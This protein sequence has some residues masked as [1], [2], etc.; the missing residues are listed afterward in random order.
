MQPSDYRRVAP[1]PSVASCDLRFRQHFQQ[2]R[3][4]RETTSSEAQTE[5][6][7]PV[8]KLVDCLEGFQACESRAVKEPN[9][10]F[11]STPAVISSTSWVKKINYG[12]NELNME[13][14]FQPDKAD[15]DDLM[16]PMTLCDSAVCDVELS[17]AE[18]EQC[19]LSDV[20]SPDTL[21]ACDESQS[22]DRDYKRG[23][24]EMPCF[25]SER[26]GTN[27]VGKGSS[28]AQDQDS[29][30]HVS[31]R[32]GTSD[33]FEGRTSIQKEKFKNL[34]TDSVEVTEP[35]LQMTADCNL[36][37]QI[38]HL[39]CNKNTTDYLLQK[40]V[41]PL[42]YV[43]TASALLPSKQY[44]FGSPYTH[45]YYPQVV[46]ERQ[47]VLSPSLDELS[48]R[49][50]MFS[51]DAEEDL[52][53]GQAYVDGG[54]LAETGAVSTRSE[55]DPTN[56]ACSVWAKTCACC[57][58]S[59]PDEDLSPIELMDQDCDCELEDDTEAP[60][61]GEAPKTVRKYLPRHGLS[62]CAQVSKHKDGKLLE[63]A[64]PS[65]QDQDHS[66]GGCGEQ[67]HF[68]AKGE[69]GRTKGPKGTQFRSHSGK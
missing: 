39:P 27:H 57:G 49:D 67:H 32:I 54:T 30:A 33:V 3:M 69:R 47:S 2:M 38:L 22:Q 14:P 35:L 4:H 37:Y 29:G 68:A 48:S 62:P 1:L 15:L 6:G 9:M 31:D 28:L 64:E 12:N 63:V 19:V 50:E 44:T 65:G 40:D 46:S 21:A 11:S 52:T 66:R 41:E 5:P 23:D 59:L 34:P 18:L 61:T 56:E 58:A 51:T 42:L 24:P 53:S 43:G 55:T 60:S 7:D 8:S 17:Q 13:Q 45:N 20:L 10:M 25:Q 36:P 26:S 16:K